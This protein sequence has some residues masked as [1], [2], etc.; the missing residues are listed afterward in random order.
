MTQPRFTT[1][2]F[3][4]TGTTPITFG[5]YVEEKK[6]KGETD[7]A[8]EERI[9]RKK[10]HANDDGQVVLQP[11]ALRNCIVAAAKRIGMKIPG[12]GQKTYSAR[13]QQGII[14]SDA[15]VFR[16]AK[17]KAI[18]VEDLAPEPMFVR[19]NE[20]SNLRVMRIFPIVKAGW[21]VTASMVVL[22]D[23]LTPDVIKEHLNDAGLFIGVGSLRPEMGGVMGRFLVG[24]LQKVA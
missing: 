23:L 3:S 5:K 10:A 6:D 18:R 20:K 13:F 15:M 8:R 2:E 19:V 7:Q 9:W 16:D 21:T 14:I 12:K 1:Y 24:E 22:D 11:F 17:G 4:L